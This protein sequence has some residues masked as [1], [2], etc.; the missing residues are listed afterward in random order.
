[1]E[2]TSAFAPV[3]SQVSKSVT[4]GRPFTLDW[5]EVVRLSTDNYTHKG[6]VFVLLNTGASTSI[7]D[8]ARASKA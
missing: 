4:P 6:A 7:L 2:K 3:F 5:S 1:V 8:R